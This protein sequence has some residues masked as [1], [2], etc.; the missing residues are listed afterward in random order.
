MSEKNVKIRFKHK[1]DTEENWKQKNPVLLM[2]ELAIVE[3][4]NK[5]MKIKCGDGVS[6][7]NE[8]DYIKSEA[9][10]GEFGDIY[11]NENIIAKNEI[12]SGGKNSIVDDIPGGAL[13]N[14]GYLY[15]TSDTDQ[16]AGINIY[17]SKSPIPTHQIIARANDF[18]LNT[19]LTVNGG[20]KSGNQLV[21]EAGGT[22]GEAGYVHFATIKIQGTYCNK[23]I[24]MEVGRRGD[25]E[26]TTLNIQF[27]SGNTTDPGLQNFIATGNRNCKNEFYLYKASAGTW[28]LFGKKTESWDSISVYRSTNPYYGVSISIDFVNNQ[29]TSVPS[30]YV[31]ADKASFYTTT[32]INNYLNNKQN[33]L[34][35]T[36]V[37]QAG[38]SGQLS[39][40]VYIGWSGSRLKAQVDATDLGNIVF[41]GRL[42][43]YIATQ[44]FGL[45]TG[46]TAGNATGQVTYTVTKSGYT[47]IAIVSYQCYGTR[48][49]LINVY[50]YS[51]SGDKAFV[52]YRNIGSNALAANDTGIRIVVLYKQ[53]L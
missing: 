22:S 29:Y 27:M 28:Y 41:D 24:T 16:N 25:G 31:Q 49:S 21:H 39:N 7:F 19:T 51:V 50:N 48:S 46:A 34:G 8:L 44:Q 53:N 43:S 40:T 4:S 23:P 47:P 38:G 18:Y 17:R 45:K 13:S 20:I 52:L 33:N 42:S 6:S 15:L 32:E 5:S 26:P 3:L 1:Y 12:F 2:G 36:P 37:R 30:G 11:S 14:N 10:I 9:T 35:F